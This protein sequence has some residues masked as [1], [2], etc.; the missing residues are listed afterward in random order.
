MKRKYK[1]IKV[2]NKT[3]KSCDNRANKNL[4]KTRK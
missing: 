3:N 2:A 1:T 4:K